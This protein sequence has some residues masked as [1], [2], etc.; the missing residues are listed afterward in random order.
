MS[1]ESRKCL[2]TTSFPN[3]VS[4]WGVVC[5]KTLAFGEV[6]DAGKKYIVDAHPPSYLTCLYSSQ[7]RWSHTFIS[8]RNIFIV[9]QPDGVHT[10]E[11]P[12]FCWY[13]IYNNVCE[14]YTQN[15]DEKCGA[16]DDGLLLWL[17]CALGQ[18]T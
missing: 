10:Y 3:A 16:G 4:I 13:C 15:D 12:L 17:M 14:R 6:T 18:F 8:A 1:C 7:K 5:H 2:A 11:G 9:A